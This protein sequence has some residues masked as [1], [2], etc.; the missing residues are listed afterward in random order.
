MAGLV[1][2][3]HVCYN[4]FTVGNVT[5]IVSNNRQQAT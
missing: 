4:A 5:D 2:S 1:F 3:V